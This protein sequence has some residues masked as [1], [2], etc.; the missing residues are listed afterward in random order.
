MR[1]GR[2]F[3]LPASLD[4]VGLLCLPELSRNR[5]GSLTTS[6]KVADSEEYNTVG[7][8]AAVYGGHFC[9]TS[10]AKDFA[11]RGV[12][13]FSCATSLETEVSAFASYEGV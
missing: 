5:N 7:H 3:V 13:D 1:K 11:R 2:R 12:N 9:W 4:A 8:N 6:P 10:L